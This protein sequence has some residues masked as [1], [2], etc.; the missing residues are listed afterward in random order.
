MVGEDDAGELTADEVR[1][2]IIACRRR[3]HMAELRTIPAEWHKRGMLDPASIEAIV[4]DR[5]ERHFDAPHEPAVRY[6]DFL[7]GP[8]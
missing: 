5:L 1:Q 2:L 4:S 3:A 7:A 6:L 8:S